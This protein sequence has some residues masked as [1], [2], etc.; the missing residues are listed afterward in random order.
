MEPDDSSP[1]D[2]LRQLPSWLLIRLSQPAN[3]LVA[4]ALGAPGARA[5]FAVLASLVEFGPMSQADLGRRLSAD[6]SDMAAYVARLAGEQLVVRATDPGDR[7]RNTV[8][9]TA[10]GRR[11]LAAMHRRV[12]R[13]QD[14]LLAPLSAA[15]RAEFLAVLQ[16]LVE[17]HRLA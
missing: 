6:R 2:R 17:H 5:D 15:R 8:A 4:D 16:E 11:R 10:R 7:R 3:R 13:A 9:V 12:E 1:P 14:D